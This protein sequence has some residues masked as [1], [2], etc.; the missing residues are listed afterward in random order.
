MLTDGCLDMLLNDGLPTPN[1]GLAAR[2]MEG[3]RSAA[4]MRGAAAARPNDGVRFT[5]RAPPRPRWAKA[6][7]P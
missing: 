4:A 6:N 2:G 1:D 3:A 7:E 5:G